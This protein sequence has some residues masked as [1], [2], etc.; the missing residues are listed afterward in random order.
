MTIQGALSSTTTNTYK[1]WII[2]GIDSFGGSITDN[3]G[4]GVLV[5]GSTD[6]SGYYHV[7]SPFAA[8][9]VISWHQQQVNL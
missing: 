7:Y 5:N 1:E 9:V 8:S 3:Q 2:S 6:N 4:Y